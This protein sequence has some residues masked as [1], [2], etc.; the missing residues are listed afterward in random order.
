MTAALDVLVHEGPQARAYLARLRRAGVRPRTAVVIVQENDAA[1]GKPVG[2]LLPAG[3]RL[4]YAEKRQEAA[5]NFWP[6]QIRMQHPALLETIKRGMSAVCEGAGETIDAALG[7]FHY[8]EY[9]DRV[10]RVAA[11]G[12]ADERL[13]RAVGEVCRGAVLFTGGGLLRASLLDLPGVRFIHVHPGHL[14]F[15]RGADGFLWSM[16]VRGRPGFSAF[17]MAK[18]IDTGEVIAADDAAEVKF[19]L[20]GM[21]RPDDAMLYR[22]L[23]SF[24]DPL[25][26]AEF[27]ATQVMQGGA[28][29]AQLPA[30]AQDLSEGLTYHF[31]HPKLRAEALRRVFVS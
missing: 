17:Y 9:A 29:P 16:L 10:V 1:T 27:L 6:R 2:R 13:A 31:L 23:F 18:G 3:L 26:R 8:E 25:M 30:A 12:L 20:A 15:V 14:P 19:D 24:V 28:D 5:E 22:A 4:K 21:A 7:P 11:T